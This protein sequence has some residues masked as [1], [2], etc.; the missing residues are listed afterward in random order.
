MHLG[1][2]EP[3]LLL[4]MLIYIIFSFG[5][6]L[7]RIELKNDILHKQLRELSDINIKQARQILFIKNATH[8]IFYDISKDPHLETLDNLK[9]LLDD[10]LTEYTREEEYMKGFRDEYFELKT[11]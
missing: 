6:R 1:T 3:L 4:V 5:Q 9:C 7:S 2:I 10:A 11:I 8:N